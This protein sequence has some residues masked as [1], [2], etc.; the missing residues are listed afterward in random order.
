LPASYQIAEV[1]A[2]VNSMLACTFIGS[3]ETLQ[4]S[5]SQ[6]IAETGIDELM[7]ATYIYDRA[8]KL[9]SFDILQEVLNRE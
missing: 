1:R 4:K 8:A 5:L 2:H 9:K 3:R 7:A 6:F